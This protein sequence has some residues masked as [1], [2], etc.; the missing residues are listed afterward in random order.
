MQC[1]LLN[2]GTWIGYG[3]KNEG[4]LNPW[5]LYLVLVQYVSGGVHHMTENKCSLIMSRNKRGAWDSCDI[6][7]LATKSPRDSIPVQI[8]SQPFQ[9]HHVRQSMI[10]EGQTPGTL[11]QSQHVCYVVPIVSL[12]LIVSVW[13]LMGES[14]S[15]LCLLF[16]R[17]DGKSL[18]SSYFTFCR[19]SH[20]QWSSIFSLVD[21]LLLYG[22][23][24]LYDYKDIITQNI[25]WTRKS[26]NIIGFED[27]AWDEAK[28]SG[29]HSR[30]AQ[31]PF[32][33]NLNQIWDSRES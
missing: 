28:H 27:L 26:W 12:S 5:R 4:S 3:E 25:Y 20:A 10:E 17:C 18:G 19:W 13:L 1:T 22:I 2:L 30:S 24:Q 16:I 32:C 31:K 8:S 11:L 15:S 21:F 29:Q 6:R 33:S 7:D 9:K 14:I 23:W